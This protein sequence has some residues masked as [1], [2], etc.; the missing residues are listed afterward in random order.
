MAGQVVANGLHHGSEKVLVPDEQQIKDDAVYD[1][2]VMLT[3]IFG[4]G[5]PV[6]G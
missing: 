2:R 4:R 5:F 3:T 6:P 1:Y